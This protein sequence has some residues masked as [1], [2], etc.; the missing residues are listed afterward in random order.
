[1]QLEKNS[2]DLKI[3]CDQ[4]ALPKTSL[5]AV[6]TFGPLGVNFKDQNSFHK[7]YYKA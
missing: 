6:R 3:V 7:Q 2:K 5:S 1:M 4:V